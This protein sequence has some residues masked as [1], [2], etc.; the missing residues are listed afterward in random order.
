MSSVIKRLV[1]LFI[2]PTQPDTDSSVQ[3][4][5]RGA[6]A[7]TIS[8]DFKEVGNLSVNIPLSS[9]VSGRFPRG[10]MHSKVYTNGQAVLFIQR[11]SSPSSNYHFKLLEGEKVTEWG[12]DWR[13]NIYKMNVA[14]TTNEFDNYNYFIKENG[15]PESLN[16]L[17]EM[18]D[19]RVSPTSVLRVLALTP[20]EAADFPA[21][22]EASERYWVEN[23]N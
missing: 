15:L 4:I 1:S 2:S 22:P 17:V 14:D 16:Y 23:K 13:K 8:S 3:K 5:G 20:D 21:V 18:Y 7:V 9:D 19:Y 10:T 11:M 12:K 6:Y